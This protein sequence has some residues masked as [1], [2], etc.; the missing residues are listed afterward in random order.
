M[1]ESGPY[2]RLI[3]S[4]TRLWLRDPPSHALLPKRT[5]YT[6]DT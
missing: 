6:R 2:G 5:L 3:P 4:A 1:R